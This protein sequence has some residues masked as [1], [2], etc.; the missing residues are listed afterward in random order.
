[1]EA[2]HCFNTLKSNKTSKIQVI[3][4]D[5]NLDTPIDCE[6]S[7]YEEDC[8]RPLIMQVEEVFNHEN[9][10]KTNYNYDIAL[11]KLA[12]PVEFTDLISPACLPN[13]ND[14]IDLSGK[15]LTAVGFG[16]ISDKKKS[17]IKQEIDLEIMNKDEFSRMKQ[18]LKNDKKYNTSNYTTQIYAKVTQGGNF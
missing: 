13:A 7:D 2:A 15:M 6:N 1:V 11:V 4:G 18:K 5:W 17:N 12:N 3:L 9:F 8:A 14:V 16:V 10:T